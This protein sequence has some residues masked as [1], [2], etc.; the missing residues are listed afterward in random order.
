MHRLEDK[1]KPSSVLVPKPL[2]I[3]IALNR[4]Y[5]NF[6]FVLG[7][8]DNNIIYMSHK[9]KWDWRPLGIIYSANAVDVIITGTQVVA[10]QFILKKA[11]T[12]LYLADKPK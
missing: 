2:R 4:G 7:G 3:F 12:A 1:A 10:Y 6:R 9:N 8:D 5:G 11:K